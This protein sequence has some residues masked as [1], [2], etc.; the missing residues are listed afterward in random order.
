MLEAGDILAAR[1]EE[2]VALEAW[3]ANRVEAVED[4]EHRRLLRAHATWGVLRRARQRAEQANAVRTPTRHA[5]T[6][7][8]A[9]IAFLVWLAGRDRCLLDAEQGDIEAWLAEGPASAH[10]VRNFL[11]WAAQRKLDVWLEVS[12]PPPRE[13]PALDDEA[14]WNIVR[15]LLQDNDLCLTDRWPVAWSCSTPSS[16]AASSP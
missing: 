12:N 6:R 11:D 1:N 14:R 8:L 9:A 3:V 15:R 16:S 13:G 2:L 4:P 10:E 5:K 7:L